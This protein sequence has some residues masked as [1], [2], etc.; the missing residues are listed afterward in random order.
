MTDHAPRGLLAATRSYLA[1]RGLSGILRAA[2]RMTLYGRAHLIVIR[3]ALAGPPFEPGSDGL[4]FRQA[5]AD[6]LAAL[7]TLAPHHRADRLRAC[8]AE[9]GEWLHVARDGDRIVGFRRVSRGISPRGVLATVLRPTPDQVYTQDLFVHPDY[10]NR[11]VGRRISLAQD[12]Q[13][14]AV[15]FKE[16]L[17]SVD[18]DNLASLRMSF[19]KGSRPVCVVSYFRLLF[20]RRLVV[21]RTLPHDVQRLLDE[22]VADQVRQG[23]P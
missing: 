1:P 8:V 5:T 14:A 2:I 16:M 19:R 3:S 20:Y 23:P 6:D 21:S 18:A 15:G 7:E 13:L 4:V 22:V 11:S 10:R 17:S 12:R 9:A